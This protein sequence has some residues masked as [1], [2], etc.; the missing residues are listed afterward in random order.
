MIWLDDATRPVSPDVLRSVG[1]FAWWYAEIL[2][3]DANGIVLIWSYGLPFLPGYAKS[4]RCGSHEVPWDRPSLNISVYQEGKPTFYCLHE[5][6][7][8][9][10]RWD[11]LGHWR[12]GRTE[13]IETV[14]GNIRSVDIRVDCPLS[15]TEDRLI[16]RVRLGGPIPRLVA[17]A[18]TETTE[19]TGAHLWTPLISPAFGTAMLSV[20]TEYRVA[21]AGRA[22]HDRNTSREALER[23]GIDTW[24]WGHARTSQ[25]ERIFYS[26]W[27]EEEGGTPRV[28]GY[29]IGRDGIIETIAD[30]E[31]SL[32][33]SSRTVMGMRTWKEVTLRKKG[34]EWL[35]MA[36]SRRVDNGPFYLRYLTDSHSADERCV[37]S[38]EV[39]A[40]NRVDRDS[41]RPFVRMRVSSDNRRN[42]IWLPLFE[43]QK[44]GRLGRLVRG[45]TGLGPRPAESV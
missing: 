25:G 9:D 41:H 26:L 10:A 8:E 4:V 22:Y 36:L 35:R 28:I 20:G 15:G 11:G 2:D 38:A 37:G 21:V 45:M 40:P 34:A 24:L 42:S 1:G 5:F 19:P 27:G 7:P 39:I 30:L 31:V 44:H 23:L 17:S 14:E 33:K 12:F 18:A 6:R 3:E 32:P 43:G 29:E 13:I 16:G